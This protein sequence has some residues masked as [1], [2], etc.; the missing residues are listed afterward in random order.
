MK[1][2]DGKRTGELMF[3]FFKRRQSSLTGPDLDATVLEARFDQP[4]SDLCRR[5]ADD[6]DLA[7]DAEQRQVRALLS[8]RIIL[9]LVNAWMRPKRWEVL[10]KLGPCDDRTATALLF[11]RVHARSFHRYHPH[12]DTGEEAR[13]L[14]NDARGWPLASRPRA[15]MT[16]AACRRGSP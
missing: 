4:T 14:R 15:D 9:L 8:R 12:R 16:A 6:V 7:F 5:I 13:V 2:I 11:R 10:R 3:C 1:E